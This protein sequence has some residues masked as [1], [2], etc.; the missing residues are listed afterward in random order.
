MLKLP[1]VITYGKLN[2]DEING[3]ERRVGKGGCLDSLGPEV[4]SRG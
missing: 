2:L 3:T 4:V 1:K